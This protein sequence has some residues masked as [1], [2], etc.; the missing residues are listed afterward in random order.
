MIEDE[1]AELGDL[2]D[3]GLALIQ[4]ARS[5]FP[6]TTLSSTAQ[7]KYVARPRNFVT[8]KVHSKRAKNITVTLRGNPTE[9]LQL[10]E[11]PLKADMAGY[12]SFKLTEVG[13]LAAA[14]T[15]IRRAAELHAAGRVREQKQ[16][17]LIER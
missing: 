2:K 4:Y 13:Q 16:L 7:G 14:A 9:F 6:G 12:S 1:I 3:V 5:I 15:Y 10:K 11:L 17:K 8:F